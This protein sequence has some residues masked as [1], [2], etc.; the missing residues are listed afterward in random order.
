MIPEITKIDP[1][2]KKWARKFKFQPRKILPKTHIT[3]NFLYNFSQAP[4]SFIHLPPK[5]LQKHPQTPPL[6]KFI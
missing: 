6:F 2:S 1:N 4:N 3:H 5:D